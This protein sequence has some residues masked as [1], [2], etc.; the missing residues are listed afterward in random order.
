MSH[1]VQ[2]DL[3][4]TFSKSIDLQSDAERVDLF[5]AGSFGL[6]ENA[7]LP[8]QLRGVSDF[9]TPHQ[10][11]ANW[12]IEL[13]F[14]KGKPIGK[15]A[16]GALEAIIGGWQ[17]AGLARWTSGFPVSIGNGAAWPTNWNLSPNATQVGPVVSGTTKNPDGS[18]NLFLD[19]TGP[20]GVGAFIRTFPG[21]S[22]AR[23]TI[24]GDGFAGLDLGLSKRWKMPYSESHSLQFRWEVFN[25]PNLK[26][27]D[28]QTA[29]LGIDSGS[30]G[31]ITGL[32]TN[33]RVMQFTMRYDF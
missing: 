2:F 11:N 10:I 5:G 28:V 22:G 8:K 14:G 13:P 4:Y 29:T 26:R 24:R 1:G 19:P 32:L 33:P 20:K 9:D 30:F 6:I 15:D 21:D 27:F 23:N 25:V 16:H 17:L 31:N 7:W 12:I 18:V 3:N